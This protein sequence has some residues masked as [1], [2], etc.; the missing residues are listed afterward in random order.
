MTAWAEIDVA[1]VLAL[2]AANEVE[3]S[4]LDAAGLR[5]LCDQAFHV[6]LVERGRAAFLIAFDQDAAYGSPNFLWFKDR[7]P[8]FVYV[9]RVVVS[10]AARGQRLATRLYRELFSLAA[11]ARHTLVTCEVNVQPPNPASWAFHAAQGFSE[12]GRR[13]DANALKVVS[14]LVR[15][16]SIPGRQRAVEPP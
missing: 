12:V 7:Y 11:G 4:P 5:Q 3:T 14:Y 10:V 15:P 1:A 6:G 13:A 8:S 9:D 16:L 2:N